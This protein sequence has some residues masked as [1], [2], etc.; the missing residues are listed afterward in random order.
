MVDINALLLSQ[1]CGTRLACSFTT[2]KI[3]QLKLR[4]DL[5]VYCS[6]IRDLELQSED[7]MGPA[8]CMVQIVTCYNFVLDSFVEVLQ[9]VLGI[10]AFEYE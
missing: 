1:T 5:V 9:T 4:Y 6:I 8:T 7:A 2:G 10:I 3:N